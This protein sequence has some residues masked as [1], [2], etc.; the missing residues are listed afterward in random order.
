MKRLR[1][2]LLALSMAVLA[3]WA[4]AAKESLSP[5]ETEMQSAGT[6]AMAAAQHGPASIQLAGQAVLNLPKGYAFIPRAEAKRFL[7]AM[8][9][10]EGNQLQGM[11]I[12]EADDE[13][14]MIIAEYE[15]SGYIKD[16]EARDWDADEMLKNLKEGTEEGNKLRRE[17]G[18]PEFV[19]TG[20]IEK[21]NYDATNHRLV[22]SMAL[23]DKVPTPGAPNGV[24][25]NTYALGR[26]G[27][28][29]LNLVTDQ[30]HVE[31]LKPRA[32]ELLGNLAF[33]AGKRYQDFNESTDRVAEYGIAALVG[34]IAAK[35]LG[36]L[37]VIA[38]FFAKS[39][40][41]V[42]L[43]VFGGFAAIARFFKR[44]DS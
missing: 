30:A 14:W 41:L 39:F 37:A 15:S 16:D 24:N 32:K 42:I 9:N 3:P 19:V 11:I 12:P 35:K 4:L 2:S 34:G 7:E 44:K 18:I 13:N 23:Q 8:G 5:A 38:A 10:Q 40:K 29:S 25:Y 17:K 33:S 20:W 1:Q 36:L 31:A 6:V 43:A 27:Y 21:P 22:W 26:E 28:I